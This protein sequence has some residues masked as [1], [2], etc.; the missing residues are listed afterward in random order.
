MLCI[1][2]FLHHNTEQNYLL[3]VVYTAN[4]TTNSTHVQNNNNS[5]IVSVSVFNSNPT[6][7]G[8]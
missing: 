6:S 5:E 8:I 2:P 3:P 7:C 1:C 4:K